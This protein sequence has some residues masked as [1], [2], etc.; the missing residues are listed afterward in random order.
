MVKKY[1]ILA[2]SRNVNTFDTPRQLT[3][4]FG[5]PLVKR[6]I[7]LLKENGVEDIIVTSH[8]KRF[9]N[10]G[11][12]RYEPL[13]N[14]YDPFTFEGYWLNGFPE[15]LLTE[16]VCFIFGDVYFSENAIKKI[17]EIQTD[18]TMFFCTHSNNNKLYIKE[19]DEPLAY[20][21][22]DYELFKSKIAETKG[23][24]DR[25][26][27]CREPVVW[28]LYRVINGIWVN[29]HKLTT[30]YVAINDES[31]DIDSVRDATLINIKLGGIELIKV[32][33]IKQFTLGKFDEITNITRK[34]ANINGTIF[35]G[36]TFECTNEMAEYL[37]GRNAKGEVVVKVVE[38]IPVKE[39]VKPEIVKE[40]TKKIAK[41]T[42]KKNSK[43]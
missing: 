3:K 25:G 35:V 8:D 36:D 14:V 33:A 32:E 27:C 16:P 18:S 31:C 38:I 22:E 2:D 17:V 1:I 6:T 10:L 26:V 39:E 21:V 4:V 15:E 41:P 7:R 12:T 29:E 42:K 9:D 34:G 43:K 40:E 30:N 19:H 28:E 13:N 24:K 37:T 20:K 11:A 23:L 5:E